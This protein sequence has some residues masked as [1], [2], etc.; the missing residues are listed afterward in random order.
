MPGRS[1]GAGGHRASPLV[2]ARNG[3]S[4]FKP[5]EL[6]EPSVRRV[7]SSIRAKWQW[8]SKTA[9]WRQNGR[10][11]PPIG[12]YTARRGSTSFRADRHKWERSG[13]PTP[14]HAGDVL[15]PPPSLRGRYK[16]VFSAGLA[17]HFSPTTS[18]I[19]ALSAFLERGG[20]LVTISGASRAC[21]HTLARSF[22][23]SK[24]SC[25]SR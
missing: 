19:A 12:A 20:Y 22:Y 8:R 13:I 17:E 14:I 11:A 1:R 7:G 3:R 24:N 9:R 2:G 4:G 10:G 15:D 5:P 21:G 6:R 23:S 25:T 18:I 16:V